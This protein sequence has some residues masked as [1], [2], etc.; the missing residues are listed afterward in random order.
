MRS[1][2]FVEYFSTREASF[3]KCLLLIFREFHHCAARFR[4]A[5][6]VSLATGRALNEQKVAG[7]IG[8]VGMHIEGLAT[9]VTVCDDIIRDTFYHPLIE[10]EVFTDEFVFQ[11]FLPDLSGIFYDSAFQLIYMGKAVVLEPCAGLLAAYTPGAVHH[12]MLVAVGLQ[13]VSHHGQLFAEAVCIRQDGPLEMAHLAFV[14]VAHIHYYRI[15]AA[16]NLVEIFGIQV[17]A[18]IGGVERAVIQAISYDL[19][20]D[21]YL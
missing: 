10:N 19:V 6:L 7:S 21:Q 12:D 13:H 15:G 20:A 3:A 4:A 5:A 9:L 11:P 2:S 1:T 18:G 14:V 17:D 8:A 16:C